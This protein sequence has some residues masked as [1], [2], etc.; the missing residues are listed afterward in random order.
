MLAIVALINGAHYSIAKMVM[1]E[2]IHPSGIILLR[3]LAAS[4]VFNLVYLWMKNKQ[5]IEKKDYLTLLF[6]SFFGIAANQLLFFNGLSQ[7]TPINAALMTL[8]TPILVFL[9][10]FFYLKDKITFVKLVGMAIAALGAFLLVSGRGIGFSQ[11][12]MIGD[13]LILLNATSYGIFLVLVTPLMRKYEALNVLRW[14]FML[15]IPI[16]LPFSV[17]PLAQVSWS[18]L[19]QEAWLSLA[20]ILILA[21]VT[22][23]LINTWSLRY[24]SPSVNGIYIYFQP[25]LATVF[26]V[27]LGKDQLNVFK[28]FYSILIFIG[29]FL[30]SRVKSTQATD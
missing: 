7:T 4:L 3:L 21:T 26:A 27:W 9:I 23:Y 17:Q 11:Q 8:M 29:V 6:C 5:S 15:S 25:F 19:T 18:A 28:I 22:T 30:V 10:S 1:P 20:F 24:V 13:L 12:T 16:V 14:L 2:F